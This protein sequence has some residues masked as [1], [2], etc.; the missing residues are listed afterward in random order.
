[1]SISLKEATENFVDKT[2]GEVLCSRE[3]REI[4]INN[5]T[6]PPFVK[7]YRGKEGGDIRKIKNVPI[8]F[9]VILLDNMGSENEIRMGKRQKES[10]AREME[11]SV[12]SIERWIQYL[13]HQNI[14]IKKLDEQGK[15]I[16]AEYIVCPYISAIGNW[17]DIYEQQKRY[18]QCISIIQYNTL[19]VMKK[20]NISI[21][22]KKV[23]NGLSSSL[24][25]VS[26]LQAVDSRTT[27]TQ[28]PDRIHFYPTKGGTLFKG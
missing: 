20:K 22:S 3:Y 10:M 5:S 6:E 17:K 28:D 9:W 12:S 13:V 21:L 18:A 7:S 14:L 27:G 8:G 26:S 23:Q 19:P 16:Q 25:A 11:I 15:P 2:T 1:M 4:K 24:P